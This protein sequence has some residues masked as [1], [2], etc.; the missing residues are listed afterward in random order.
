M[1]GISERCQ[2]MRKKKVLFIFLLLFTLVLMLTEIYGEFVLMV[3]IDARKRLKNT[4]VSFAVVPE[5]LCQLYT[6]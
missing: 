6:L 1:E 3:K 4:N 2:F 5:I